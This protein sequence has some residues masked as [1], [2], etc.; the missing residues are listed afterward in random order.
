MERYSVQAVLSAVDK[1]FTSNMK[2]ATSLIDR[3]QGKAGSSS[4]S[5]LGMGVAMGVAS[6]VTQKA[7]SVVSGAIGGLVGDLNQGSATWKTFT[8]NMENMGKSKSE[9]ASVKKELQ[10]FATKTI[11]SASD[12]ATTYSQLAAVGIK[13]TDKLVMG[14][15]GL[16]AAAA[17]PQQAMKTLSQQATQMAA[18]PMVQWQDFKLMLEQTPA[19]VAAV[20]KTMGMSTA[21]LVKNVQD[22]TVETQKFFDAVT[23]TGTNENFTKMAT[24]YKTVGQALDGLKET[25]TGKL[26]PAFDRFSQKGI[27]QV[28]KLIDWVSKLNVDKFIGQLDTTKELLD[29]FGPLLAGLGAAT[30]LSGMLPVLS[31]VSG[32]VLNLSGGYK[33]AAQAA[34]ELAEKSGDPIKPLTGF[35]GMIQKSGNGIKIFKSGV[36]SLIGKIPYIGSGLQ[37]AASVGTTAMTGMVNGLTSVMGLALTALGPAAILGIALVGLGLVNSQFGTQIQEMINT[38]ITKGPAIIQGLVAGITSQIPALMA[39]GTQ[40]LAQLAQMIAVNLPVIIQAGVDIINALVGGVTQNMGSIMTSALTIVESLITSLLSAAPQLL[41]T[42]LNLLLS[43]VKG[44]SSNS[45]KIVSTATNIIKSFTKNITNNLPEI[46]SKG[47]DILVKLAEGIAKTVPQLIPV[48][49]QAITQLVSTLSDNLPKIMDAAMKIVNTL[50]DALIDNLPEI[51]SAGVELITTIIQAI[52]QNL[53]EIVGAGIEITAKL[54]ATLL[55]ALPDMMSA[56]K[57][58]VSGFIQGIGDMIGGVV[59]K[60]SELASS[61]V[62]TVKSFL[63]IGSPSKVLRQIGKWTGEGFVIGMASMVKDVENQSEELAAAA[64]P[65][66]KSMEYDMSQSISGS[67]GASMSVQASNQPIIVGNDQPIYVT[68]PDGRVLAETTAPFMGGIL[69]KQLDKATIGKGRRR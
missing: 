64:L 62:D 24:Q 39:S 42:G 10:D 20:A 12:M 65:D 58:L 53:P 3:L 19:G 6:S 69:Q 56:G 14:F 28:S 36:S 50:A 54:A 22:G 52:A 68:L 41:M 17:D 47:I 25:L 8:G 23:T 2:N 5:M 34:I 38:A 15:G 43:L 59:D 26:Q 35:Y 61:A 27:D 16:A 44:I 55:E 60:A 49:I 7:M 46:I 31:K 66:M 45:D 37:Q 48:A 9:I 18:K 30:G 33:K 13:N 57:D 11:Y 32:G 1:G 63:N 51:L 4:N 40:L 29:T 67:V 21:E